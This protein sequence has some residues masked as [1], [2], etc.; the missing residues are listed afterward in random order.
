MQKPSIRDLFLFD[1]GQNAWLV[2]LATAVAGVVAGGKTV[3][4]ILLG[5]IFDAIAIWGAGQLNGDD[6]LAQVSHWLIFTCVLG[7]LMWLFIGFD[8]T[9]WMVS[10]EL[11]A[12]RVRDVLF[13]SLLMKNM[14]WYDS[15]TDGTAGLLSGIQR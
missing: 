10:G 13:L 1:D 12:K 5:K 6:F 15:R 14:E 4:A 8:M 7:I 9:L 11:R 3:Y 2:L